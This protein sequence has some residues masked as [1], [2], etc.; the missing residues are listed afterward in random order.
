[1][2][3]NT[4]SPQPLLPQSQLPLLHLPFGLNNWLS[5]YPTAPLKERP[6]WRYSRL[7]S[8]SMTGLLIFCT[9]ELSWGVGEQRPN[10][11]AWT[12]RFPKHKTEIKSLKKHLLLNPISLTRIYVTIWKNGESLSTF[13]YWVQ[14]GKI[15]PSPRPE[16]QGPCPADRNMVAPALPPGPGAAQ[17]GLFS[18]RNCFYKLELEKV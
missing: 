1:M 9:A 10:P 11:H 13:K 8:S 3:V 12:C 4:A 5:S 15:S 2:G 14:P 17:Q 18:R 6:V 7:Q 16:S